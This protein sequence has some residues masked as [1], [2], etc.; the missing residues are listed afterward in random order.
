MF[1]RPLSH[2]LTDDADELMM[3]AG[4]L[5]QLCKLPQQHIS[6]VLD[7]CLQRG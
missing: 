6:D 5:D 1:C 7:L 2:E 3:S 4:D